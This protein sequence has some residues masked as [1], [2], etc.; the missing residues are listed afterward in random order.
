MPFLNPELAIK[1]GFKHFGKKKKPYKE[2]S[3]EEPNSIL[4]QGDPLEIIEIPDDNNITADANIEE[5]KK[6]DTKTFDLESTID[7]AQL[8]TPSESYLSADSLIKDVDGQSKSSS[9]SAGSYLSEDPPEP[10]KNLP[11]VEGKVEEKLPTTSPMTTLNAIV[12]EVIKAVTSDNDK[13]QV[14]TN[15]K[16]SDRKD[17][18]G[19]LGDR[20][21]NTW[22]AII[23]FIC[24]CVTVIYNSILIPLVTATVLLTFLMLMF[25]PYLLHK[26][27]MHRIT[28]FAGFGLTIVSAVVLLFLKELEEKEITYIQFVSN[29][30][31][32]ALLLSQSVVMAKKIKM[33][34]KPTTSKTVRKALLTYTNEHKERSRSRSKDKDKGKR[35]QKP[36]TPQRA[37]VET[38]EQGEG[39]ES[40]FPREP[41]PQSCDS[42]APLPPIDEQ[43]PTNEE[44]V[45]IS[46]T[47]VTT[48]EL[49]TQE[50]IRNFESTGSRSS[51]V[52]SVEGR[53]IVEPPDIKGPSSKTHSKSILARIKSWI[54]RKHPPEADEKDRLSTV[55]EGKE[56]N[57][58]EVVLDEESPITANLV[59]TSVGALAS[60]GSLLP[61]EEANTISISDKR[62]SSIREVVDVVVD[63][64][65]G[66][67]TSVYTGTVEKSNELYEHPL[68]KRRKRGPAW[69]SSMPKY[70]VAAEMKDG[71]KT[72]QTRFIQKIFTVYLLKTL[73]IL[74]VTRI[75]STNPTFQEIYKDDETRLFHFISVCVPVKGIIRMAAKVCRKMNW[76]HY[77]LLFLEIAALCDIASFLLIGY[78]KEEIYL[79]AFS[80]ILYSLGMASLYFLVVGCFV[81]F[82]MRDQVM[83]GAAIIITAAACCHQVIHNMTIG[84]HPEHFDHRSR[85]YD[86]LTCTAA[87]LGVAE[88]IIMIIMWDLQRIITGHRIPNIVPNDWLV[89]S[90]YLI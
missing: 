64:S 58:S 44:E 20:R 40:I 69:F 63:S 13:V 52:G 46:T 77:I 85:W 4:D 28:N 59:K 18:G 3:E 39:E 21:R 81:T 26:F 33:P 19:K 60:V 66:Q 37:K 83:M 1:A 80:K 90:V 86:E 23:A 70:S 47:D 82:D 73:T 51:I 10:D 72:V 84:V 9:D 16:G 57:D 62:M 49:P 2:K 35:K 68:H 30:W 87:A 67:E 5:I 25:A 74:A 56:D 15:K 8:Q 50:E 6:F 14:K 29:I 61:D 78:L 24:A 88:C 54:I 53:T 12:H 11:E 55:E 36:D 48:A 45:V 42:A 31:L 22:T 75:I 34:P 27:V 79:V 76:L 89:T 65:I 32:P 7:S 41:V 43:V 17:G 71:N 38:R